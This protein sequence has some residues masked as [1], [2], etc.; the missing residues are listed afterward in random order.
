MRELASKAN[1]R[2]FFISKNKKPRKIYEVSTVRPP[3]LEPGTVCLK[4]NCSTN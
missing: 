2:I 4:G 3:G 1:S